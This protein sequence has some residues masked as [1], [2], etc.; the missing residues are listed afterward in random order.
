MSRQASKTKYLE[1]NKAQDLDSIKK[2]SSELVNNLNGIEFGIPRI[3]KSASILT[4]TEKELLRV[5]REV[6]ELN[7][8]LMTVESIPKVLEADKDTLYVQD[9]SQV[10]AKK[11][12]KIV[13]ELI[14]RCNVLE[15]QN[16]LNSTMVD[17]L[18]SAAQAKNAV[19]SDGY[20]QRQTSLLA[21]LAIRDELEDEVMKL[22]TKLGQAQRK[23]QSENV[24]KLH[25]SNRTALND[26]AKQRKALVDSIPEQERARLQQMLDELDV[27]RRKVH[28]VAEVIPL[29]MS[30]LNW[31][32]DE[33]LEEILLECGNIS[34]DLNEKL[35][36][37]DAITWQ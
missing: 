2:A 10:N 7:L 17:N 18:L 32:N 36:L 13:A 16:Y 14:D 25:E 12:E 3:A 27:S 34:L 37:E 6:E 26:L 30:R 24:I 4:E 33:K 35:E 31:E 11:D 1:A 20:S 15:H 29:L 28:I 5:Y 9:K 23:I 19:Y 8:N 22:T 21:L